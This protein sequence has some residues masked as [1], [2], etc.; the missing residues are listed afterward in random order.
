LHIR[1]ELVLLPRVEVAGPQLAE[2]HVRPEVRRLACL[3]LSLRRLLL[4]LLGV[5]L[6]CLLGFGPRPLNGLLC[7]AAQ[8]LENCRRDRT[9]QIFRQTFLFQSE[10]CQL[11]LNL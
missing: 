3:W 5:C 6:L 10:L 7:L 9:R 11:C 2:R 8:C 4:M 1:L